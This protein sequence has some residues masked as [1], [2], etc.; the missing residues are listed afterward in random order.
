MRERQV[1]APSRCAGPG[2]PGPQPCACVL[3]PPLWL[4][5]AGASLLACLC[6]THALA[7]KRVRET[8]QTQRRC[9][10]AQPSE[11]RTKPARQGRRRLPTTARSSGGTVLRT[12]TS[13]GVPEDTWWGNAVTSGGHIASG[14]IAG[15]YCNEKEK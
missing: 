15:N 14:H 9:A 1:S 6:R 13:Y 5:V 4:A 12:A 11:R 2:Q 10:A 3:R 8:T 7:R